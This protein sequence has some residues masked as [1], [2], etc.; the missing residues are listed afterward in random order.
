MSVEV[1]ALRNIGVKT[2]VWLH[3]INVFTR[4]DLEKVGAVEAYCLINSQVDGTS[5]NLLYALYGALYDIAW[6]DL[7][8]NIKFN[9]QEQVLRFQFIK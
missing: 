6:H 5:L 7:D 1:L 2:A 8:E 4:D 3:R 9:L